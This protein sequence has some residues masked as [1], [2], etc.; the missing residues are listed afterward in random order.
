M[1]KYTFI[2]LAIITAAACNPENNPGN[3]T[4]KPADYKVS[5]KVEK[6]PFVSG[7][8]INLQP[9]DAKY[10]A[11]GTNFHSEIVD[12]A[13]NFSLGEMTL[14]TPYATMTANGYFFNEVTGTLSRG[15]LSLNAIVDL[16]NKST[17]NVNLLT[18]LKYY[19]V[20]KLLSTGMTFKD[21]D[22]QAQKELFDAFGLGQFNTSD[23]SQ[24]SITAGTDQAGALIA[25][26]SLLLV[27]RSEAS[28]TEFLANLSKEFGD[29]GFFAV[30]TKDKL[31]ES[32]LA[33]S[34]KTSGIAGNIVKRYEDLGETVTVKDLALYFDWDGNGVVGDEIIP[35]GTTVT[36]DQ[37]R[38]SVPVSGGTYT[39]KINSPVP[40][41]L[42]PPSTSGDLTPSD[43]YTSET[44]FNGIYDIDVS[45]GIKLQTSISN[46]VISIVVEK[47][48]ARSLEPVSINVYDYFGRVLLTITVEQEADT[49]GEIPKLGST[50]EQYVA[51]LFSSIA[52]ALSAIDHLERL[53]SHN[54]SYGSMSAPIDPNSSV[55]YQ[56]WSKL[57]SAIRRINQ[58]RDSEAQLLNVYGP[59]LDFFAALCYLPMTELWGDVPYLMTSPGMDTYS[60]PRN[61]MNEILGDLVSRL[62]KTLE[63]TENSQK[64]GCEWASA[65]ELFFMSQ[66]FVKVMLGR[67]YMKLGRFE[68]ANAYLQEV[69]ASEYYY[70][71]EYCPTA[72]VYLGEEPEYTGEHQYMFGMKCY[73]QTKS[74]IDQG[75][76]VIIFSY[77][78]VLLS[79]AECKYKIGDETG[80]LA[81]VNEVGKAHGWEQQ[82]TDGEQ[83]ISYVLQL[84][85]EQM[86][87]GMFAFMKR[88]NLAKDELG[89]SND[90]YLLLPIPNQEVMN[91]SAM[92]QN[93]GY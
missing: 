19:R 80:A 63:V 86:Y 2:A 6:G 29:N 88:N 56:T 93:P 73:V 5:G 34:D 71:D 55:L 46:N 39:V 7:S 69:W 91:N 92:T 16:T 32:M 54:S 87:P 37:D 18:H 21:A 83:A 41:F 42:T 20:Q 68:E 33:L 35:E 90:N 26:S 38:I 51:G 78:E 30:E 22:S 81:L 67:L 79:L 58:F 15:T 8:T 1:K 75:E 60:I 53:Y 27:G 70:L 44:L 50:G 82:V 72:S 43:G 11:V 84:R 89:I 52:E 45:A 10:N 12:N 25:I 47:A 66:N 14:D 85:K 62:E 76:Y 77:G 40:V 48:T 49:N 31:H 3:D 64:Y 4:P 59:Y 36:A 61:S 28:I 13:G 23:V 65:N 74:G 57:Y 9:L 17:V 24:Y